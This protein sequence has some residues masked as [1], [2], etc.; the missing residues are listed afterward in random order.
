[1]F[2]S[3]HP[4]A[5][6]CHAAGMCCEGRS[7][8]SRAKPSWPTGEK[9]AV[10]PSKLRNRYKGGGLISEVSCFGVL[11]EYAFW[12]LHAGQN[13]RRERQ[14]GAVVYTVLSLAP[15]HNVLS[16][17]SATPLIVKHAEGEN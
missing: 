17:V 7:F 9:L 1:M 4:C 6:G 10:D 13:R 16:A 11:E 12:E 3:G 5:L 2:Y 14:S 15:H 8:V